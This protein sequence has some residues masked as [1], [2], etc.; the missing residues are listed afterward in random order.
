MGEPRVIEVEA[1]RGVL[2]AHVVAEAVHRFPVGQ[3][4][5]ALEDHHHGHDHGRDAAPA[6]IGEQVAEQ[7]VG[8]QREAFPVEQRIDGVGRDAALAVG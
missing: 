8:E 6:D 1:A 2:R 7:V 5:E 4:V 3:A